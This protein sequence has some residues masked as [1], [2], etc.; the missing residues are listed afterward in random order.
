MRMLRPVLCSLAILLVLFA[1]CNLSL[2]GSAF[3][4]QELGATHRVATIIGA[5]WALVVS[6]CC[7]IA[8]ARFDALN[9]W[10]WKGFDAKS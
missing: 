8:W 2:I 10:T 6:I 5:G 3:I 4:A 7:G 1:V 9:R